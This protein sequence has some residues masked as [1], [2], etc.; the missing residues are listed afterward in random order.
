M[1]T[2]AISKK[3]NL[4]LE[5]RHVLKPK[6]KHLKPQLQTQPQTTITEHVMMILGV[7]S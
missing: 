3:I 4:A 1:Q 5:V 2:L 6:T 7:Y